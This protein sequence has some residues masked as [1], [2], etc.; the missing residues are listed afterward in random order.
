MMC[1][2]CRHDQPANQHLT[3]VI[4]RTQRPN[5]VTWLPDKADPYTLMLTIVQ[6]RSDTR[7]NLNGL[8]KTEAAMAEAA[9][10]ALI[11]GLDW[12]VLFKTWRLFRIKGRADVMHCLC[13]QRRLGQCRLACSCSAE[14]IGIRT[15]ISAS[16]HKLSL[17]VSWQHKLT[18]QIRLWMLNQTCLIDG[19]YLQD[20]NT[21]VWQSQ[22]CKRHTA[23]SQKHAGDYW[24]LQCQ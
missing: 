17:P 13:L 1:S 22:L 10:R 3:H 14:R 9:Q 23:E 11:A 7:I 5:P 2:L 4:G 21:T 12:A 16:A 19:C 8:F 15:Q 6:S 18:K 24:S 20:C